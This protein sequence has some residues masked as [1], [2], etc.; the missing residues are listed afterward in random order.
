MA[1]G[2]AK[3]SLDTKVFMNAN[4]HEYTPKWQK[5]AATLERYSWTENNLRHLVYAHWNPGVQYARIQGEKENRFCWQ[6]IDKWMEEKASQAL[7]QL[8]P[9]KS[10]SSLMSGAK[11]TGKHSISRRRLV[12]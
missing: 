11:R 5:K 10:K 7:E 8:A 9:E 1:R 4:P 3:P 12:T 6:E 2:E